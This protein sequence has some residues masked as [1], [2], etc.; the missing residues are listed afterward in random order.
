MEIHEG[1]SDILNEILSGGDGDD[2]L[3]YN[4]ISSIPDITPTTAKDSSQIHIASN[5]NDYNVVDRINSS[6]A[7][8]HSEGCIHDSALLNSAATNHT[9]HSVSTQD[10][11]SEL[12]PMHRAASHHKRCSTR[13]RRK[14]RGKSS[15][16]SEDVSICPICLHHWDYRV[17]AAPCMQ[18]MTA[19]NKHF[20]NTDKT[21]S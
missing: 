6:D 7:D 21:F 12:R 13:K 11:M 8:V 17:S 14:R 3:R 2:S 9:Q 20:H 15:R 5:N 4:S 19:N 16:E 10:A 18:H 1:P